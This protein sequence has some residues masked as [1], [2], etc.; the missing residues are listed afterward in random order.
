MVFS[1][2]NKISKIFTVATSSI[3]LSFFTYNLCYYIAENYFFDKFFYQK[4]ASHGYINS[5]KI[6]I[7][8]IYG[9][10]SRDLTLLENDQR[11][12]NLSSYDNY[13]TVLIVGDSFVWGT[14]IK[15]NQR[16]SYLL[17]KKLNNIRPTKIFTLGVPGSSILDYSEKYNQFQKQHTPNLNIISI[18]DND[19]IIHKNTPDFND[20]ISSCSQKFPHLQP[21]YD[22]FDEIF[23]DVGNSTNFSY[24][25]VFNIII[26]EYKKSW[27]NPIN[28]CIVEL[29]S[30]SLPS[31][32]A[33]YFIPG[34]YI[35]N[36]DAYNIYSQILRQTNKHIISSDQGE[37]MYQYKK[38]WESDFTK[39][40][41]VSL[42][43]IHPS[44]LANQMYA[45][46]LYNEIVNNPQYKFKP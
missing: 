9:A 2:K 17:E 16:F 27:E 36:S 12:L 10:R 43:E 18:V 40:F 35:N 29:S 6:T 31:N 19:A 46:I 5:S 45:D 42:K 26:K 11:I 34:N 13:Y 24:S 15:N 21:T 28:K 20:I 33:I 8:K 38:Y 14:G 39:Y 23:S 25:D 22:V 41:Q 4:S 44:A 37:K 32:N 1:T 30:L 3:V 7:P